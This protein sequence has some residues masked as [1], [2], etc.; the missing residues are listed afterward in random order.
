MKIPQIVMNFSK[1]KWVVFADQGL[2]SGVNFLMTILLARYLGVEK[3]GLFALGWM[4]VLFL[5]SVQ[6]AFI[7]S[8]LYTLYP[9]SNQPEKYLEAMHSIQVIFSLISGLVAFVI[10][11]ITL[12]MHP[13]WVVPGVSWCLPLVAVFFGWQDFYRRLNIATG[14]QILTLMSDLISYGLQPLILLILM[15]M[16]DLTIT[17][18]FC[19][20][21]MLFL[22]GIC[23]GI[24]RNKFSH[25]PKQIGITLAANWNFSKFLIGTSFLQWISGNL[26]ILT[27]ASILS[28]VAIGIIRIAQNVVGLLN[29]LFASLENIVPLKAAKM[30][31]NVGPSK[32]LDYFKYL[33][34]HLG[35]GTL[36]LLGFIA[37]SRNYLITWFY[38][39]KYLEF[40]NVILAFTLVYFLVFINTIMGF[41]IRTFELNRVFFLNYILTSIFSVLAS[42]PFIHE[43]GVYGVI[44]GLLVTQLIQITMYLV[45][46]KQNAL[47]LWK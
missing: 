28:P 31:I 18:F 26:F 44:L 10:T 24:N 46:L 1:T 41:I 39:A 20:L 15:V 35:M 8:P 23:I 2:V 34:L 7:F 32:T 17:L 22:V 45:S 4:L 37:L 40:S 36:F 5:S 30:L 19:A 27:A 43:F 38:G 29:V 6:M 33:I 16:N 9:K 21:G 14:K 42:K 25:Q 47:A 3:F 12:N 13:E 11:H